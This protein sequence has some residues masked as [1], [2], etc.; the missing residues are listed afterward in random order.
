MFIGLGLVL[1]QGRGGSRDI[2]CLSEDVAEWNSPHTD[3]PVGEVPKRFGPLNDRQG[4]GNLG[5]LRGVL[6]LLD[7]QSFPLGLKVSHHISSLEVGGGVIPTVATSNLFW[8]LPPNTKAGVGIV[9]PGA[10]LGLGPGTL[11]PGRLKC[12]LAVEVISCRNLL[13]L[14]RW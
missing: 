10:A 2:H 8:F 12:R 14:A 6:L 3:Y 5:S 11:P 1:S 7:L 9:V 4:L 13:C